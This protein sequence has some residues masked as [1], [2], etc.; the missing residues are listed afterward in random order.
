VGHKESKTRGSRAGRATEQRKRNTRLIRQPEF[1]PLGIPPS[2]TSSR[3]S[4][5]GAT[6]PPLVALQKIHSC[7]RGVPPR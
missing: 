6:Y 4:L 5:R 7:I 2:M 1:G 3:A